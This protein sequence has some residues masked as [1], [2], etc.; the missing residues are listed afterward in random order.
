VRPFFLG[1]LLLATQGVKGQE[2]DAYS[3][4]WRGLLDQQ[5]DQPHQGALDRIVRCGP[6][7]ARIAALFLQGRGREALISQLDAEEFADREAATLALLD[8]GKVAL[9]PLRKALKSESAEVRYRAKDLITR[10]AEQEASAPR[11]KMTRDVLTILGR[12]GGRE[13]LRLLTPFFSG[14]DPELRAIPP[15]ASEIE[16]WERWSRERRK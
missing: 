2:E 1:L 9:E 14:E 4:L 5:D 13:H 8:C 7:A 10:I 15:E 3:R 6:R 16:A 12:S 11:R